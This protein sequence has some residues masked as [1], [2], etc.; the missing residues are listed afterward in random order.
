MVFAVVSITLA[1]FVATP[2]F[3]QDPPTDQF[4][5]VVP[6]DSDQNGS[7]PLSTRVVQTFV[8][9]TVLSLAPGIAMMITCLP[10]MVVVLSILRQ[11]IGLQQAP[12]NM[13]IISLAMFLTLF[14]MEPVFKDAWTLGVMPYVDNV[15]TEEQAIDRTLQPFRVFMEGRVASDVLSTLADAGAISIAPSDG[16]ATAAPYRLLIPAFMLSEIQH[17]FEVGFL[18]FLPFVLIDL[19]VASIL[20]AMGMMMVPPAVI[21]L[22]FKLIFFVLSNGWAVVA[23]ALVRGYTS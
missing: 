18:V 12:P 20:M 2:A 8:V 21:S 15:I 5:D 19:I 9:I 22:P 13:M 11:A 10:F 1:C 6:A 4:P 16:N 7:S 3:A 17:A 23:A 14:V